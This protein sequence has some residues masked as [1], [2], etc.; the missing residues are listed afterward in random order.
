MKTAFLVVDMQKDFFREG[1]L[2]NH[3]DRLVVSIN[4]LVDA[5][6]AGD[7]PVIWVRQEFS[8]DLF[9]APLHDRRTGRRI[10][11]EGT[12]GVEL[13]DGLHIADDDHEI[14]KKRYSAFFETNLDEILKEFSI[15]RI[16]VAGINTMSCVRMAAI[17]AYQRDYD[18][19]LALDAVD[20]Y[21][22]AQHESTLEYLSH[23]IAK[24]LRNR[25]ILSLLGRNEI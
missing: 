24:E 19:I 20:A 15:N 10:T 4:E 7:T 1:R 18:V 14:I 13:L 9:D 25:E 21:D 12:E 11:I 8:P 2:A 6:H 22:V 17:D 3:H 16:I 23:A 5:A